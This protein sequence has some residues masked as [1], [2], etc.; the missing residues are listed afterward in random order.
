MQ[1]YDY[2]Y[3]STLPSYRR[4]LEI[5]PVAKFWIR[6]Q[7]KIN[8]NLNKLAILQSKVVEWSSAR[9]LAIEI[10]VCYS[11]LIY[12]FLFKCIFFSCSVWI[13]NFRFN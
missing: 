10:H 4:W 11:L 13:L 3:N 8:T 2:I 5:W 6:N 9:A 7:R 1:A 12:F